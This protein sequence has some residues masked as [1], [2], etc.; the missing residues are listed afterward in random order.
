MFVLR[1]MRVD[2]ER[3]VGYRAQQVHAF[4]RGQQPIPPGFRF[5]GFFP[6]VMGN[7]SLHTR[8]VTNQPAR[9]NLGSLS[10]IAQGVS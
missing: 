10:I 4:L 5:G 6:A 2:G 3:E 9:S 8:T 1:E 7:R